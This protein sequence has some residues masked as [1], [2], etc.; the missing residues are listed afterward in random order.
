LYTFSIHKIKKGIMKDLSKTVIDYV[1]CEGAC[2]AGIATIDTLA[3]GPPSAKLT[4]VLKNA[5]SAISF[6]V[7]LD[8]SLIPPFLMK[9][10]RLSH[11]RNNFRAHALASGTSLHLSKFLEQKGYP[12]VPV[13]SN[14]VYRYDT[15]HGSRDM[16]P[17]ISLR[18]LAVRSG[19]G[20]FGFSGNVITKSYGAAVI[21]G[22]TVTTAELLPTD[23]LPKEENYCDDCR[24]CR[25]SCVSGFMDPQE[26]TCVSLGGKRFTYSRRRNYL[27]CEFV[28]AGF[29]G[30]HQFRKWST[31][32]P[33]RFTVPENDE[34][35]VPAVVR[36]LKASSKWP[37]K[38][39]KRA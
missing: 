2:E 26:K 11:E 27:R 15:Q 38:Y 4:Y 12:S 34:D 30:L 20:H 19:V 31:W 24:L 5:K 35:I 25:A 3:G 37:Q 29:T 17:D 36:G 16:F 13:A 33:G 10:D 9:K 28:C 6:A 8:Q 21:L 7:A 1:R 18:Y 22:A 32:S 39:S 23:P 14:D